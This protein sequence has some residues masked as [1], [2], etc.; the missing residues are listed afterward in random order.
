MP[1][2]R[3]ETSQTAQALV[4]EKLRLRGYEFVSE[5]HPFTVARRGGNPFRVVVAG[6]SAGQSA[7]PPISRD[8]ENLFYVLV[9]LGKHPDPHRFFVMTQNELNK[10]TAAYRD[11]VKE[12]GTPKSKNGAGPL[13]KYLDKYENKW[14]T[15]P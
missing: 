3:Q 5:K 4:K 11:K 8:G 9:S 14:E 2:K 15:L 12:D 7:W 6:L 13:L 10:E 1:N